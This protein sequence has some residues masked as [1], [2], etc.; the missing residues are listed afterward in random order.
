MLKGFCTHA[1]CILINDNCGSP[2]RIRDSDAIVFPVCLPLKMY[3]IMIRS[4]IF[5]VIAGVLSVL[6]GN[7]LI[8]NCFSASSNFT[9]P[10]AIIYTVAVGS[11]FT[12]IFMKISDWAYSIAGDS[13]INPMGS[14]YQGKEL[15]INDPHYKLH[16]EYYC[17]N[18]TWIVPGEIVDTCQAQKTSYGD[19]MRKITDAEQFFGP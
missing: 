1:D 8:M 7:I 5:A 9:A 3:K 11:F 12:F 15:A 4:K 13:Q 14:D 2:R 17:I 6:F 10:A 18:Q 16:L 19:I